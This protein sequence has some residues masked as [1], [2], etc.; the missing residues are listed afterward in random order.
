MT[1]TPTYPPSSQTS[2]GILEGHL[3]GD[4]PVLGVKLG[5]D[6][7]LVGAIGGGGG[8]KYQCSE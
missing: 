3:N 6:L 2:S 8:S 7:T 5:L 1:S 4:L